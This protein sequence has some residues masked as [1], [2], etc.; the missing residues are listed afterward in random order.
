MPAVLQQPN[1]VFTF[2]DKVAAEIDEDL[3]AELQELDRLTGGNNKD[4]P[5]KAW[6]DFEATVLKGKAVETA[7]CTST[8]SETRSFSS[9]GSDDGSISEVTPMQAEP[10][11]NNAIVNKNKNNNNSDG[12]KLDFRKLCSKENEFQDVVTRAERT[13]AELL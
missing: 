5:D 11:S 6:G 3:F 12:S 1:Y 9:N 13:I 8:A 4:G 2:D 7:G 10:E